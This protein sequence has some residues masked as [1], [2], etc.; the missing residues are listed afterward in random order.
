MVTIALFIQDTT[1]RVTLKILLE[2]EGHVIVSRSG[3]AQ[4]QFADMHSCRELDL[5]STPTILIASAS[6]IPGAVEAMSV[7]AWGYI[8]IPF[9][10]HEAALAVKRVLAGDTPSNTE[11]TLSELQTMEEVEF[12]YIELALRLCNGNQAKAARALKIGRNTL[13]RKLRKMEQLK[14]DE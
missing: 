8:F 13:W 7:G 3:D 4:V 6:D 5:L 11:I 14:S 9:Q 1:Q 2:A 12:E 10:P